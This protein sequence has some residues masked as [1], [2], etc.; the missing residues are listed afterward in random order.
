MKTFREANYEYH[1]LG[2]DM[3]HED[4]EVAKQ[5]LMAA[6]EKIDQVNRTYPNSL[7]M[8]VFAFSKSDEIVE[9]FKRSSLQQKRRVQQIMVRLDPQNATKYEVLRA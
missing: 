2:L 4:V 3:M 9:I 7:A 5:N 1:R 6:L 8:Y